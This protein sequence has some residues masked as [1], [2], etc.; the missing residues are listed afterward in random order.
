MLWCSTCFVNLFSDEGVDT[1]MQNSID[2]PLL[3]GQKFQGNVDKRTIGHFTW[4][5]F[6][7][8]QCHNSK[9]NKNVIRKK[10][11]N[12]LSSWETNNILI[13]KFNWQ[14][15]EKFNQCQ[16]EKAICQQGLY[17]TITFALS[18]QDVNRI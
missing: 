6:W 8:C 7:N 5:N 14:N 15:G 13:L 16:C 17:I 1:K 9:A 18:Q 2:E 3:A 10:N 4:Y 11:L 12:N